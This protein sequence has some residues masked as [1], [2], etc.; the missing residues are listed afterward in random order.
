MQIV[1]MVRTAEEDFQISSFVGEVKPDSYNSFFRHPDCLKE[2]SFMAASLKEQIFLRS[3]LLP[4][5]AKA[6]C[7]VLGCVIEKDYIYP[8][9]LKISDFVASPAAPSNA[10]P[11][12]HLERAPRIP[13]FK[14]SADDGSLQR[15]F[16]HLALFLSEVFHNASM[17]AIHGVSVRPLREDALVLLPSPA[18]SVSSRTS[19]TRDLSPL[20]PL[21]FDPQPQTQH[22]VSSGTLQL[23]LSNYDVESVLVRPP[24]DCLTFSSSFNR[25][26][27]LRIGY[28]RLVA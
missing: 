18:K 28:Q 6:R 4:S 13:I 10:V 8:L 17:Q 24:I 2:L 5:E 20:N 7:A 11:I 16:V 3:Y 27:W 25:F 1:D 9:R 21:N 14:P 23:K 12:F 22:S 19:A 15:T 26:F